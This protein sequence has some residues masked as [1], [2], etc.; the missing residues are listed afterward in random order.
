MHLWHRMKCQFNMA[1]TG[2]HQRKAPDDEHKKRRWSQ[3]ICISYKRREVPYYT[4]SSHVQSDPTL[5]ISTQ[6]LGE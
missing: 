6:T 5:G 3:E 2:D 4:V 1:T